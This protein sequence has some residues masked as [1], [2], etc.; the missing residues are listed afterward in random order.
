MTADKAHK[1]PHCGSTLKERDNFCPTCGENLSVVGKL[2]FGSFLKDRVKDWTREKQRE[3]FMTGLRREMLLSSGWDKE[4]V[5]KLAPHPAHGI[6]PPREKPPA[7]PWLFVRTLIEMIIPLTPF[8]LT[9]IIII[10]LLSV[11][12]CSWS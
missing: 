11:V 4:L 1:C 7:K 3:H 9:A 8:I 5:D 12:R 10:V 6:P 2:L